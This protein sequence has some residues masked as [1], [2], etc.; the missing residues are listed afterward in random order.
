M[1][2]HDMCRYTCTC[3]YMY[4]CIIMLQTCQGIDVVETCTC[5]LRLT[6]CPPFCSE[7]TVTPYPQ[8]SS[9]LT[10]CPPF[11][12]KL[13]PYP[14]GVQE[15]ADLAVAAARK[16]FESWST[17]PGHVRARHMYSIARHIQK[18]ARYCTCMCVGCVSLLGLLCCC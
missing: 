11:C 10:P 12:S 8:F 5:R 4:S 15:D 7:L 13:T 9:E 6:S 16:A 1:Q 2:C 17:L 3:M 14:P 18:H